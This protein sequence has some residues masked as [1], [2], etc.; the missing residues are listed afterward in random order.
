MG[1]ILKFIVAKIYE[2]KNY[3]IQL[4]YL[5]RRCTHLSPK[6]CGMT[7]LVPCA[8]LTSIRQMIFP[9]QFVVFEKFTSAY[10][11][12]IICKQQFNSA[13]WLIKNMAINP[14]SVQ[15]HQFKK[16]KLRGKRWN[17][18]WLTA[19]KLSWDKQNVGQTYENWNSSS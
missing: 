10:L 18:K 7:E 8:L 6:Y 12:L 4:K 17:W 1:Q 15:F 9:V 2:P 13:F 16:V 5:L 14:K 19:P 3:L 11:F